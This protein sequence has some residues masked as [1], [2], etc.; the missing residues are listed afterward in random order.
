MLTSEEKATTLLLGPLML[1]CLKSPLTKHHPVP[2]C[3]NTAC[4]YRCL[5]LIASSQNETLKQLI[6]I[7]RNVT[8][9]SSTHCMWV[10]VSQIVPPKAVGGQFY[11]CSKLHFFLSTK[12]LKTA[13]AP[14]HSHSMQGPL[15]SC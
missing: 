11:C 3:F 4:P 10:N 9:K 7:N 12:V 2:M 13:S 14:P 15:P 6:I 5:G 1:L 8:S